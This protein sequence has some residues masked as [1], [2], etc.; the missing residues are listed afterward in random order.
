MHRSLLW[1]LENDVAELGVCRQPT[2]KRPP[3]SLPPCLLT[4]A[5][6]KPYA[7]STLRLL[8]IFNAT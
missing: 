6:S 5:E 4:R 8:S 3:P 2:D 7:N 1:I